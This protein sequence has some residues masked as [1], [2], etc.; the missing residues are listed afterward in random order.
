MGTYRIVYRDAAGNDRKAF[1]TFEDNVTIEE[2]LARIVPK[3]IE[4]GLLHPEATAQNVIV[5]HKGVR[6]NLKLPVQQAAPGINEHDEIVVRYLASQINL[7]MR[8]KADDPDD[9]RKIYFGRRKTLSIKETV[10]VSPSEQLIG[11]IEEKLGEISGKHKFYGKEIKNVKQFELRAP[12]KKIQPNLS[13]AEQGFETDLEVDVKPR[14]WFDW[15][16][17]FFY[18][19]RGPFTGYAITLGIVAILLVIFLWRTD[20]PSFRVTF[21]APYE[22]N[23]KVNGAAE[24]VPLVDGKPTASLEKGSHTVYI[25]P[26]EEP[27]RKH[28][29]VLER[30][31]QGGISESD[32]MWTEPLPPAMPDSAT[33]VDTTSVTVVGYAGASGYE[34]LQ[35]PLLFN[36]FEYS[37][38]G[39]VSWHFDLVPGEYEFK[40][41][42][43]DEL[44]LSSDPGMGGVTKKSDF[45]FVVAD[46]ID[47]TITLRYNTGGNQ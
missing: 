12:K 9:Q 34:N 44:F 26:R 18:G 5:E 23:V 31:V 21:D 25:F 27:I 15:P 46:T 17:C 14:I 47:A 32:S 41:K 20:V 35:I 36:G 7:S 10:A 4:K 13:L 1:T 42:L 28:A 39:E 30:A 33:V 37:L 29:M 43:S 19:P 16:P 6:L 8:I 3:A 22:C 40:F 24:F 45:I 38:T 2:N 11:Q